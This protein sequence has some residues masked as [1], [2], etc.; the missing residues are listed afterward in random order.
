[1]AIQLLATFVST[2]LLWKTFGGPTGST[3]VGRRLWWL[4]PVGLAAGFGPVWWM[5]SFGQNTGL[6]LLGVAGFAYFGH[7]GKPLTAGAFAALTAIKPHLLAAFGLVLI[8]D[9]LTRDGRRALVAG[10]GVIG[11]GAGLAVLP[12]PATFTQFREAVGRPPTAEVVPLSHWAVPTVGYQ[13]RWAVT[14]DRIRTDSGYGF[15]LQFIPCGLAMLAAAGWRLAKGRDWNW[16]TALPGLVTLAVLATPYGGWMFDLTLLLV[17][18]TATAARLARRPTLL[19]AQL[20]AAGVLGLSFLTVY[21]PQLLNNPNPDGFKVGLHDYWWFP[22]SVAGLDA[23]AGWLLGR[24]GE[25]A[26]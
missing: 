25:P 15:G 4:V 6:P 13:L 18:L 9:A 8:L 22:L 3:P 7:R 16:S 12:N 26:G 20:F 23:L 24:A 14:A 1:V 10:V 2:I 11:I 17:P 19:P 21:L 5:T